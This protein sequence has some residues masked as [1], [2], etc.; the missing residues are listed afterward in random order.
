M[1][2]RWPVRT[3][4]QRALAWLLA[5]VLLLLA[6]QWLGLYCLTP[7]QALRQTER[8]YGIDSTEVWTRVETPQAEDET[9]RHWMLS[10]NQ[11]SVLLST[12]TF[13]PRTGWNCQAVT[14]VTEQEEPV[15]AG[16]GDYC[17]ETEAG[18]ETGY[19]FFGIIRDPGITEV[20]IS[21]CHA[22]LGETETG[23]DLVPYLE[24]RVRLT[25]S[26]FTTVDGR[27]LFLAVLPL[28]TDPGGSTYPSYSVTGYRADGTQAQVETVSHGIQRSGLS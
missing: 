17:N 12:L 7:G 1:S 9:L 25:S 22:S 23:Y 15:S 18:Y 16:Y 14:L 26:D 28:V 4:R 3:R 24:E 13:A 20:E 2:G 19:L 8:T 10:Y 5:V 6:N 11:K 27:R 21:A